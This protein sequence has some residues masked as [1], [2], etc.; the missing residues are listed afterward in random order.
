MSGI[1]WLMVL[2]AVIGLH[3]YVT[4]PRC[5][6]QLEPCS[7]VSNHTLLAVANRQ[8]VLAH[9]VESEELFR[10]K[11]GLNYAHTRAACFHYLN[12]DLTRRP[13]LN[14]ESFIRSTNGRTNRR[15]G[16]RAAPY[17]LG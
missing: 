3:R 12:T 8:L 1:R 16:C 5:A 10:L 9:F 17:A 7:N 11:S 4:F 6:L 13:N 15:I 14:R 2:G